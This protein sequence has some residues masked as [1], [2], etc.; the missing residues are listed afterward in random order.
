MK[1]R[2]I[3]PVALLGLANPASYELRAGA[4]EKVLICH[5]PPGNPKGGQEKWVGPSAV[6]AHLRH[7]DTIGSCFEDLPQ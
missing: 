6:G 7:G 4:Q 5:Y 2:L 3:L 1:S